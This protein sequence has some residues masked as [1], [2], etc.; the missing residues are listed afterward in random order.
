MF[1]SEDIQKKWQPVIEHPDLSEIKDPHKK[2]VTACGTLLVV[3]RGDGT[4][5][6]KLYGSGHV[7]A[8]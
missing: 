7:G 3:G 6:E 2:A 8:I 4:R 1:L 5:L